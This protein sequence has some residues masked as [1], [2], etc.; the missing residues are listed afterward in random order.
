MRKIL[1]LACTTSGALWLIVGAVVLVPG[2][3]H[4]A[5]DNGMGGPVESL[6]P[7]RSMELTRET[8]TSPFAVAPEDTAQG[9]RRVE[10]QILRN[11]SFYEALQALDAPHDDIMTL[12]AVIKP[13]RDLRKVQ[14]GDS[15]WLRQHP[16]GGIDRVSL[17]LSTR[18]QR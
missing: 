9:T 18:S 12:V 8:T 6:P 4:L 13:F 5:L 7:P 1:V 14:R 3:E 10:F 2:E 11:Q 16:D 17:L 15:F